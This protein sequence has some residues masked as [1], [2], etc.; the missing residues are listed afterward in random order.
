MSDIKRGA[1]VKAWD[2]DINDYTVGVYQRN[3]GSDHEPH[4]IEMIN[5]YTEWFMNAIEIPEEL[6]RQLEELGK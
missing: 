2:E 6:A 4:E 3:D 5:S 1:L